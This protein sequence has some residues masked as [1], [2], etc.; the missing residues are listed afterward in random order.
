MMCLKEGMPPFFMLRQ[1]RAS[2]LVVILFTGWF[3]AS[4]GIRKIR[5]L[6]PAI[7]FRG[8]HGLG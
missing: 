6:E 8:W 5:S 4:L 3:A 1:R 2:S 7:V